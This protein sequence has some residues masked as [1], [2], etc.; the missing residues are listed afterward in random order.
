VCCVLVLFV[1]WVNREEVKIHGEGVEAFRG[2]QH[3]L[4]STESLLIPFEGI[5]LEA[6]SGNTLDVAVDYYR[7]LPLPFINALRC[8]VL[9]PGAAVASITTAP[10]KGGGDKMKAGKHEALSWRMTRPSR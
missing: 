5:E 8:E 2:F 1:L 6:V 4:Q 10:S 7:T 3:L 9:L